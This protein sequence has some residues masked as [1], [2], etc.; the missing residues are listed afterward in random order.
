MTML[1][2][3]S[4]AVFGL[5]GRSA[6]VDLPAAEPQGLVN[7]GGAF[8]ATP[9]PGAEI[10][11]RGP[12]HEA[13]ATPVVFNPT[14]PVVVPKPPPTAAVEEIPPDQ[15]PTGADVEWIPGYWAWDDQRGDYIWVSGV[16]RDIP[17]GRQWVPGYWSE[18]PGGFGWTA[19]FW[20]PAQ[21]T[22]PIDYLPPPPASLEAGPNAPQP[23]AN[24]A[25]NPG[26]WVWQAD[27]YG[28]QPG[29][30]YEAQPDWI[31]SPASYQATP[32]GY[33]YNQGFWDYSLQRRGLP[34]APLAFNG[35]APAQS[36]SFTPNLVLPIGSLL[37]NLFVRPNT[38]RYYY[39]DYYNAASVGN[40]PGYVPWMNF[41]NNRV[42]YDPFYSSM[43]ALNARQPNWD[44][45]YREGY[46]ERFANQAARPLPTF[47][48]QRA[49]LAER[50]AR[51]QDVRNLG[52]VEP[53]GRW[54]NDQ[55][56]AQSLVA[57][58]QDHRQELQRRQSEL[59]RFQ[60]V[61]N[62]Q[63]QQ[64]RLAEANR[65]I[66]ME[67]ARRTLFRNELPRSP[68]AAAEHPRY[69][70]RGLTPAPPH[71][72]G[73]AS[74]HPNYGP[75]RAEVPVVSHRNPEVPRPHPHPEPT[76]HPERPREEHRPERPR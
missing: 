47:N 5:L 9:P 54:R 41:R 64:G 53:L 63:E 16:W 45:R 25:W 12:I 4:I 35:G 67:E 7:Q 23:G 33:V 37:A 70:S 66:T 52:L 34:F 36:V 1:Q 3:W 48:A 60:E 19:G 31:W 58:G 76:P 42:G 17:P 74:F 11:A 32:S 43:A 40:N 68:I 28:W 27:H 24:Y 18:M 8:D 51:G 39:G 59:N 73:Q 57:V 65:N 29:Y 30:W 44:Q 69:E 15:K 71:P 72:P 75:H 50:Q 22:G 61:R 14:P 55:N 13:F 26:L 46:Q 56:A 10:L 49:L 38:G 6:G 20:A 2:V 62:R 21:P